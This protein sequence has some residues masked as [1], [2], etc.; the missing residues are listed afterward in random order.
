MG[1]TRSTSGLYLGTCER[2]QCH[3]HATEC[4]PETGECQVSMV[5]LGWCGEYSGDPSL[6]Q[7]HPLRT[8][9]GLPGPHRGCSV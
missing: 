1:Y 3:G 6:R 2:C 4:H 5:L 8:I 7:H 9:P